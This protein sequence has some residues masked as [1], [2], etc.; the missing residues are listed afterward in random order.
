[1]CPDHIRRAY[2]AAINELWKRRDRRTMDVDK[3]AAQLVGV[4]SLDP[5]NVFVPCE[6]LKSGWILCVFYHKKSNSWD[7]TS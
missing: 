6:R 2:V 7:A 5:I 3:F 1:M 4:V